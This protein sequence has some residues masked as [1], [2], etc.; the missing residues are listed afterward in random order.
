MRSS[1]SFGEEEREFAKDVAEF[2]IILRTIIR[3]FGKNG[4]EN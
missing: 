3:N 4:K 1:P 2:G